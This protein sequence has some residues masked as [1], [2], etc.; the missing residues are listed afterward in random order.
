VSV[1]MKESIGE[2]RFALSDD[3]DIAKLQ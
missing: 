1:T 3:A 2:A